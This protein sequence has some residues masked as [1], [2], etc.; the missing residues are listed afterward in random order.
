MDLYYATKTRCE[1]FVNECISGYWSSVDQT[2]WISL[3]KYHNMT[4]NILHKNKEAQNHEE[5]QT[6][7]DD[8]EVTGSYDED[9]EDEEVWNDEDDDDETRNDKHGSI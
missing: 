9:D 3:R 5:V 1:V 8:V 7:D 2:H 4:N 6:E